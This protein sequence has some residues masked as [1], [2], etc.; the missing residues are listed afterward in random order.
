[1]YTLIQH[2]T[3]FHTVYCHTL[4]STVTS[5]LPL[6]SDGFQ[7]PLFPTSGLP[8]GHRPQQPACNSNKLTITEPQQ[9]SNSTTVNGPCLQHHGPLRK[10]IFYYCCILLQS[11]KH[12]YLRSLYRLENAS[13]FFCRRLFVE[14]LLNNDLHFLISQL[15]PSNGSTCHSMS[16]RAE[17]SYISF[18]S[19]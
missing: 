11:Y 5:S 10:R 2:K 19:I 6:L 8:N 3:A 16:L 9:F 7:R 1:M 12:A 17:Y 13:V 18:V 15:F 14:P 4:L